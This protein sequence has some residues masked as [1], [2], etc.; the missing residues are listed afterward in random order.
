IYDL[1]TEN[2]IIYG[3]LTFYNF[4]YINGKIITL[5]FKFSYPFLSNIRNVDNLET[6]KD[7]I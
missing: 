4:L 7:E 1:F 6:L 3:D 5:N 2:N